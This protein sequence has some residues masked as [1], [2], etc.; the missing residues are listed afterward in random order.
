MHRISWIQPWRFQSGRFTVTCTALE[1]DCP[2]LS[3]DDT[4]EAREGIESGEFVLFCA[5]VAVYFDGNEVARD[6][7]GNCIYR[8]FEEFT[9]SHRDP[10]PMNRNCS[11]MRAAKGRV[12]IC[13]YFPDMVATAVAEA[14]K[15]LCNM[16][17]LRCA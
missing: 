8:S 14:R 10:D 13:H 16:P 2:D 17:R 5:K 9:T 1:E 11:V 6:Y 7:L 15:A 3:W 12:T 4:G